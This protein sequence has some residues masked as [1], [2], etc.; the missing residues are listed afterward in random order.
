MIV[1]H[2][3]SGMVLKRN[4]KN[5]FEVTVQGTKGDCWVNKLPIGHKR[6]MPELPSQVRNKWFEVHLV[7]HDVCLT[8]DKKTAGFEILD[9][10]AEL[11]YT[12]N[13]EHSSFSC[14]ICH[15]DLDGYFLDDIPTPM[16]VSVFGADQLRKIRIEVLDSLNLSRL[17]YE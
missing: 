10:H 16:E 8:P 13:G 7:D 15:D 4:N 12:L 17:K 11:R 2:I 5:Q 6:L 1:E 14:D 9:N 3:K